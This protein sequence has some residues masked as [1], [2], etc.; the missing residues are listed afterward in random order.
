[1][2][3]GTRIKLRLTIDRNTRSAVFDFTGTG[4]E[5]Y[6]NTNAPESI[7]RS[8]IIYSLRSLVKSDIP[9]NSG[10]LRPVQILIPPRSILSPS[11]TSAVVGG[12]VET[13]QRLVDVILKPFKYVAASQGTMNNFL[14]GNERLTYY[15]TI[16]GG[17]GAGE[18]FNGSTCQCHMTNTRI[19][20]LEVLETRYPVCLEQ[21]KIRAGSGGNGRYRGGDGVIREFLF[22]EAMHVSILSERRVFAPYGMLGGQ[23]GERGMNILMQDGTAK[24]MGSKS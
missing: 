8:A 18:G 24:S 16:A 5:V 1:M 14:F 2:D 15:E 13:S 23:S 21:F 10:C 6:G 9:L 20:D 7:T 17:S 19:T 4:S 11:P 12:N 3:D 22:F